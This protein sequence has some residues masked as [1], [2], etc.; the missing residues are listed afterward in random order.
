MQRVVRWRRS[1]ILP[2]CAEEIESD[3]E[4]KIDTI[5][6]K[7]GTYPESTMPTTGDVSNTPA[8]SDGNKRA[9]AAQH[10]GERRAGNADM[11]EVTNNHVSTIDPPA[12]SPWLI[13]SRLGGTRWPASVPLPTNYLKLIVITAALYAIVNG[14]ELINA[15]S[16]YFGY[17]LFPD[18][19]RFPIVELL[20]AAWSPLFALAA[21][22]R[23]RWAW[24][25]LVWGLLV[26]GVGYFVEDP[27]T[28]VSALLW[29]GAMWLYLARR[30]PR[31]GLPA[32]RS[33]M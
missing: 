29:L 4:Q 9:G 19:R 7:P 6:A 1:Q 3:A 23:G 27:V 17:H 2:R 32:W 18:D 22:S 33:I 10:R 30:R 20:N 16:D 31:Y 26:V 15:L 13:V 11:S 14:L 25:C 8:H 21:A 5:L 28:G 24:H 12:K